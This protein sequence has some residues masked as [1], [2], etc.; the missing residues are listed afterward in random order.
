MTPREKLIHSN[1]EWLAA[2]RGKL[3]G[4]RQS[5]AHNAL[6]AYLYTVAYNFLLMRQNELPLL[7]TFHPQDLA[8]LAQEFVQ[9]VMEK[10]ARH[11]HKLLDQFQGTGK[12]TMWSAVIV[13]HRIAKELKKKQWTQRTR[14]DDNVAEQEASRGQPM[15][16]AQQSDPLYSVQLQQIETTLQNCLHT[17]T[18]REQTAFIRCIALDEPAEN[19]AQTF[20]T[21]IN[22]VNLLVYKAKRKLCSCLRR[23]GVDLD[24]LQLFDKM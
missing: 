15:H 7:A 9:E 13:R 11:D 2:L 5:Q 20:G 12:F 24:D 6:A 22:A 3:G 4:E 18:T 8:A 16:A 10:L 14:L 17:L 1:E 21:T 19:V 23:S